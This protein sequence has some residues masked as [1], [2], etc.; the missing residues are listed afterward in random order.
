MP[1]KQNPEDMSGRNGQSD[2]NKGSAT[3]TGLIA[4]KQEKFILRLTR[5]KTAVQAQEATET[6]ILLPAITGKIKL[7]VQKDETRDAPSA[8]NQG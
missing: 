4:E 8:G 5:S 7:G 2:R 3:K 6:N 1:G